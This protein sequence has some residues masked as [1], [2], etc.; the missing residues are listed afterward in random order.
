MT[1]FEKAAIFCMSLIML[2]EVLNYFRV[3]DIIL[4]IEALQ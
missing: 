1:P 4:A 3:G 2:A